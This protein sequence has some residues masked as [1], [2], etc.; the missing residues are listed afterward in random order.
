MSALGA[1]GKGNSVPGAIGE[2]GRAPRNSKRFAGQAARFAAGRLSTNPQTSGF[3][4]AARLSLGI[5]SPWRCEDRRP[6]FSEANPK[7]CSGEGARMTARM[8]SVSTSEVAIFL[9]IDVSQSTLDIRIGPAREALHLGHDQ[10][11]IEEVC[12]RLVMAVPEL[13]VIEDTGVWRRG[14]PAS[15]W[16]RA[17]PPPSSTQ[18]RHVA[19]PRQPD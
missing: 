2:G 1:P 13:I 8:G 4:G 5:P 18:A 9:R 14:R 16:P 10:H 11:V 15:W 19:L 7:G 12:Q 17:C 3:G 6:V